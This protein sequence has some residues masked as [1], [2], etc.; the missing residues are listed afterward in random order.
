MPEKGWRRLPDF[1]VGDLRSI[2]LHLA[3]VSRNTRKHFHEAV[4][5]T[6]A[7]PTSA[8]AARANWPRPL[9]RSC[10]AVPKRVAKMCALTAPVEPC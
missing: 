4:L 9:Q 7:T 10:S 6:D 5:C 1:V 2:G 3:F 8:G